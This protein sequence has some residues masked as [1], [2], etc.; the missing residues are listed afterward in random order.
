LTLPQRDQHGAIPHDHPEILSDDLV[1]RRISPAWTVADP[2]A[3]G[4]RRLSSMAF[5][6]SSGPNG[7][8][9]VDLKRQ[10]E[11]A[12]EDAKVWVTSPR[13]T[14]SVTFSVGELR[15]EGFQVGFDPLEDNPHH[16]EVWGQFTKGKK[17]KLLGMC[18]WFVALEGVAL[19]DQ[20]TS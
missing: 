17:K 12:G 9:S 2:K 10:I 13:W 6:K 8:M 5:E 1:I 15:A 20:P 7:G 4:G 11:E 19:G 16:G 14:A 3:P 18:V